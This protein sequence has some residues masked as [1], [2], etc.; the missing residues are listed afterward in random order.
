MNSKFEYNQIFYILMGFRF[1]ISKKK[2]FHF[3]RTFTNPLFVLMTKTWEKSEKKKQQPQ[4]I[5]WVHVN[6]Y[7]CAVWWHFFFLTSFHQQALN[8][9]WSR[10]NLLWYF[11]QFVDTYY[12]NAMAWK[13]FL[14]TVFVSWCR[15]WWY[16]RHIVIAILCGNLNVTNSMYA[17][18]AVWAMRIQHSKKSNWRK[19]KND[20]MMRS[21]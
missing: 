18:R 16:Y 15:W 19:T 8:C 17:W 6:W 14:V 13:Y 9:C 11:W 5:L 7:Q 10:K 21:I 20:K 3:C 2:K 1:Q 4:Q 12:V